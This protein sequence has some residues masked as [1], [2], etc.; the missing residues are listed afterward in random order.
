[1]QRVDPQ[2]MKKAE[3]K[4]DESMAKCKTWE[5][6]VASMKTDR[7]SLKR[8]LDN[9]TSTVNQLK[10]RKQRNNTNNEP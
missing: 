7:I 1:M 10:K 9:L 5:T 4:V 3:K 6:Q 2:D 8:N